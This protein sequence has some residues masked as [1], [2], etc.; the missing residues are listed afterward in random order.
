MNTLHYKDYQGSVSFE[1]GSLL[2]QMLHIDDF[3]TTY[4]DSASGAQQAFEGLV[5]DYVETCQVAGKEAAKPFKG[6]FNVRV[7]PDLHRRA[8]IAAMDAGLTLNAWVTGAVQGRLS[9][10]KIM[11]DLRTRATM[12]D[13]VAAI[14]AGANRVARF[15]QVVHPGASPVH[16]SQAVS[17]LT[18]SAVGEMLRSRDGSSQWRLAVRH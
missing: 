17:V 5:D 4:C 3:V 18:P 7:G 11:R 12:I 13:M 16:S 1:D 8:A 6:T 2:I 9:R 10:E 15:E 14:G